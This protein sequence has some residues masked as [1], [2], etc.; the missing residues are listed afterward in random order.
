MEVVFL[1]EL[2]MK[3]LCRDKWPYCSEEGFEKIDMEAKARQGK[4]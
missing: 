3:I 2:N 4:R 1:K